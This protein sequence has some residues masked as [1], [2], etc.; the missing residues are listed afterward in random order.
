M[1]VPY[2]SVTK[3]PERSWTQLVIFQRGD[4]A[5]VLKWRPHACLPAILFL[6]SV[7]ALLAAAV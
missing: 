6:P 3:S 4:S 1:R 7:H 5:R 2:T